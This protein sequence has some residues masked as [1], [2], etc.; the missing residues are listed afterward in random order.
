MTTPAGFAPV[1]AGWNV[2]SLWQADD[3]DESVLAKIWHAGMTPERL[4]RVWVEDQLRD[5]APGVAVADPANPAA[6]S[7]DPVQPI[8]GATG[9]DA[10]L[11]R[12][13]VP[14]LAGAQQLGTASS[15]AQLRF[16]RFFNRGTASVMPWP[17]D[18]NFELDTVFQPS[19]TNPIT[20]AP[21]PATLAGAASNALGGL[22][23]ALEIA[24]AVGVAVLL[25]KLV[26][27]RK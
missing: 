22:V 7:G 17:H 1:F 8:P 15:G 24:A 6:L 3:P 2:W 23:T 11:T 12:G 27:G 25:S 19:A 21:G 18:V 9:L 13:S 26:G 5:N 4:L 16:V 10:A 14:A 20:N